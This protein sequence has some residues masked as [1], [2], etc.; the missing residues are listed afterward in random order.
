MVRAWQHLANLCNR[1]LLRHETQP[2]MLE[3]VPIGLRSSAGELLPRKIGSAPSEGAASMQVTELVTQ[4][5]L[6]DGME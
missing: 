1:L 6:Q 4:A 3:V 2:C 5:I